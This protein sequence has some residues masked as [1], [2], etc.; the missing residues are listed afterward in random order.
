M[1][2]WRNINQTRN[3]VCLPLLIENTAKNFNPDYT[4]W[5]QCRTSNIYQ[6]RQPNKDVVSLRLQLY[7]LKPFMK[8]RD[9]FLG[10]TAT[11]IENKR[12]ALPLL[13]SFDNR[14]YPGAKYQP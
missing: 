1:V 14:E 6:S 5:N 7:L 11:K 8:S 10:E 2:S 12:K 9:G 4:I 13:A 3:P